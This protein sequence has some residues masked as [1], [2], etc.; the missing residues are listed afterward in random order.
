ME[1]ERGEK[2]NN[3]GRRGLCGFGQTVFGGVF[4]IGELVKS[5]L[6][7]RQR[8]LL[9]QTAQRHPWNALGLEVARTPDPL[10]LSKGNCA[11]LVRLS[12][13]G[14]LVTISRYSHASA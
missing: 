9:H 13:H 7:L 12:G 8:A 5:A 4:G 11:I 3:T 14:E 1:L 10:L 2:R 6:R